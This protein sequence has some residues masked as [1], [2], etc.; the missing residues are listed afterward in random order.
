MAQCMR[1]CMELFLPFPEFSRKQYLVYSPEHVPSAAQH[2]RD[3]LWDMQPLQPT[4]DLSG[5]ACRRKEIN[6]WVP[7]P[8]A[9]PFTQR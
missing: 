6:L 5:E 9:N 1:T 3:A 2:E 7:Q 8:P 4:W